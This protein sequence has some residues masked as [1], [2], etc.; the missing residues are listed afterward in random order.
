MKLVIT[1]PNFNNLIRLEGVV[2]SLQ[3]DIKLE[4][5][6]SY[7]YYNKD[8]N[9]LNLMIRGALAYASI[10]IPAEIDC[11]DSPTDMAI[12]IYSNNITH[13]LGYCKKEDIPTLTL[14]DGEKSIFSIKSEHDTIDFAHMVAQASEVTE[15]SELYAKLNSDTS[16]L[17]TMG[18]DSTTRF[19]DGLNHCMN[20]IN[21]GVKNNAIALYSDKMIASDNRHVFVHHIPLSYPIKS[22][23]YI[24]LHRK[25]AKTLVDVLTKDKASSFSLGEKITI[26]SKLLGFNCVLNNKIAT[27]AP[28]SQGDLENIGS[29]ELITSLQVETLKDITSFFMGFYSSKVD[30][31]TIIIT[32]LP[33][34]LKFELRN[35]GVQGYNS[36]NV[37]RILPCTIHGNNIDGELTV[38]VLI[39][40]IRDFIN[41]LNKIDMVT[42]NMDTNH[43]AIVMDSGCERIYIAKLMDKKGN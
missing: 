34:E 13:F 29:T 21:E 38:I 40:S 35:S 41:N 31:K 43:M 3:P 37:E 27:I 2:K 7:L 24:A 42:I 36:S 8:S 6:N 1:N 20:F 19:C 23:E 11:G 26:S 14:Q 9:T 12:M 32:V 16:N 4:N 28:P 17:F 22:D 18:E 39:D 33:T 30:Y 5:L 25:I 15:L 10:N